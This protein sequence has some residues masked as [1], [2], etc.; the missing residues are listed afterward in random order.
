MYEA[1]GLQ[2]LCFQKLVSEWLEPNNLPVYNM[3]IIHWKWTAGLDF[4]AAEATPGNLEQIILFGK[5]N[6]YEFSSF[7]PILNYKIMK[8]EIGRL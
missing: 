8:T 7:S 4:Y 1:P 3:Q 2:I 5:I 6:S